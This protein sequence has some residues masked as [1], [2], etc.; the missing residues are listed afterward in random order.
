M[1][2]NNVETKGHLNA[3]AGS[4]QYLQSDFSVKPGDKPSGAFKVKVPDYVFA[5]GDFLFDGTNFKS[6]SK[7][8]LPKVQKQVSVF[9]FVIRSITSL[10]KQG[11]QEYIIANALIPFFDNSWMARQIL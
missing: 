10:N 9:N 6:K 2:H 11:C 8:E 4:K 5:Q 3:V 1:K 7:I